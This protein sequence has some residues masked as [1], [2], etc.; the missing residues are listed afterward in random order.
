MRL[1]ITLIAA[2]ALAPLLGVIAAPAS[3]AEP[4][5]QKSGTDIVWGD[6]KGQTNP[7]KREALPGQPGNAYW[8]SHPPPSDID[9]RQPPSSNTDHPKWEQAYP[10]VG[11][12]AHTNESDTNPVPIASLE[13]RQGGGAYV[14]CT[15]FSDGHSFCTIHR[16]SDQ[17]RS[18]IEPN[19]T[20][21]PNW[22]QDYPLVGPIPGVEKR[23]ANPEPAADLEKRQG[24]EAYITCWCCFSDGGNYCTIHRPDRQKRNEVGGA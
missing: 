17:K 3:N 10:L 4:V 13:K 15:Y 21:Y 8:D 2:T 18:E 16:P 1:S 7:A 9:K 19:N 20:D 12:F 24:G 6:S 11:V 23:D 22:E 14:T 5:A